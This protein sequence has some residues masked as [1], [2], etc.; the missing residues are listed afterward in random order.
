M[1]RLSMDSCLDGLPVDIA[2]GQLEL[3]RRRRL[4]RRVSAVDHRLPVVRIAAIRVCRDQE[5]TESM[6]S[7]RCP[8]EH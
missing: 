6:G 4:V 8:I 2:L 1:G 7:H 5:T 3:P